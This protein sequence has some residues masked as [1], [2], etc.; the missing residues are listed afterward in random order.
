M[1][2]THTASYEP[3]ANIWANFEKYDMVIIQYRI[4]RGA[5]KDD[6]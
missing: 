2:D 3:V 1:F 4:V 6:S 5:E